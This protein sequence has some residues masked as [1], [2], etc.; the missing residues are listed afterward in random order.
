MELECT[1]M[2][3]LVISRLRQLDNSLR[4]GKLLPAN[5]LVTMSHDGDKTR[6]EK[7]DLIIVCSYT[8]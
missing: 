7:M 3:S 5:M 8:A 4:G 6:M 1:A 2:H